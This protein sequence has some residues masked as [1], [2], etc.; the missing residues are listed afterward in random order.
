MQRCP[1]LALVAVAVASLAACTGGTELAEP[2]VTPTLTVLP[3]P[4]APSVAVS[5]GPVP[6]TVPTT[7][8]TIPG[9]TPYLVQSGDTMSSIAR[10]FGVPYADLLAANPLPD[11]GNLQIG[12][13][14]LIPPTTAPTTAAPGT[15]TTAAGAE[16]VPTTPTTNVPAAAPTSQ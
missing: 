10:T 16:T 6:T 7:T 12:Q 15:A 11:P 8:T 13:R 4:T 14:L 1:V 3:D 2:P 9:S 5:A